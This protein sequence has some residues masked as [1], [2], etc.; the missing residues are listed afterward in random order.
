MRELLINF[1]R[2]VSTPQNDILG[3]VTEGKDAPLLHGY[4]WTRR[5]ALTNNVCKL[6]PCQASHVILS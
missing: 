6:V 4:L 3:R 5:Q 1:H 2:L